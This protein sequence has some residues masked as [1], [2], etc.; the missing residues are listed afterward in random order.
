MAE[1][2][3]VLTVLGPLSSGFPSHIPCNASLGTRGALLSPGCVVFAHCLP[4]TWPGAYFEVLGAPTLGG[5]CTG[6]RV[7]ATCWGQQ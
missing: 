6:V 5:V 3:L 2:Q 7:A 4:V 1:G